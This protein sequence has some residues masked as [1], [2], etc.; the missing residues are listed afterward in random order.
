MKPIGLVSPLACFLPLVYN[1]SIEEETKT[2]VFHSRKHRRSL[3]PTPS[4]HCHAHEISSGYAHGSKI[5]DGSGFVSRLLP[6]P[7]NLHEEL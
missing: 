1:S 7:R 4:G 2:S 3:L 5:V 6:A